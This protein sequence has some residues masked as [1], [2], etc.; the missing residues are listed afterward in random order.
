VS[1]VAHGLTP[2]ESLV[3]E[4]IGQARTSRGGPSGDRILQQAGGQIAPGSI[5]VVLQRLEAK[6]L[7]SS[8]TATRLPGESGPLRRL[9]SVTPTGRRAARLARALERTLRDAQ[10]A[11]GR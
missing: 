7:V 5:Y 8:A 6:G 3:L 9:Y 2:Q 1:S 11:K 10:A 4:I